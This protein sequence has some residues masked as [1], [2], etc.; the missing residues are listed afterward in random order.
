MT[1]WSKKSDRTNQA[2]LFSLKK[3]FRETKKNNWRSRNEISWSSKSFKTKE[4]QELESIE[5]LFPKNIWT[6]EIK[7]E[8]D[9]IRKSNEKI[10]RKDLKYKTNKRLY[11]V[12]K[13]LD[14]N[15]QLE[16]MAKF[17]RK[18]KTKIKIR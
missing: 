4:N 18:S 17:N 2:Y 3:N 7:N 9:E 15:N 13:R 14:Q 10:K 16:N 8:K 5:E 6:I 1:L 11:N 12:Y